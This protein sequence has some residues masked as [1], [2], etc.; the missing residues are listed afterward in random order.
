[1]GICFEVHILIVER[2][3]ELHF[4]EFAVQSSYLLALARLLWAL[5]EAHTF[6]CID[7]DC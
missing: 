1:M 6:V 2:F 5:S 7:R 3:H 4:L